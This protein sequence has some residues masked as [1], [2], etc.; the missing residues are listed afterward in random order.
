[1]YNTIYIK[2]KLLTV[3]KRIGGNIEKF[4]RQKGLDQVQLAKILDKPQPRVSELEKGKANARISTLVDIAN[5][6]DKDIK[7]LFE[8]GGG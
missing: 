8:Q 3:L 2:L 7:D 5:A 4:R 1:L 6:L